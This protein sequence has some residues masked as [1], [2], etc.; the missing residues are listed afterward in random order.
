M[1]NI[2]D[3]PET[4]HKYSILLQFRLC[5]VGLIVYICFFISGAAG[6]IYE[7]VWARQLS[8]FLGITTY[9][10]TAVI[11]AYMAGLAAG[12]L[13]IGRLADRYGDSLRL[14]AW[15]EM[16]VGLYA[17]AT[18]WLFTWIQSAYAGL[19]GSLGISGPASHLLRFA[20]ALIGMLMP[21]FLMGGTLPLL[22]RGLTG[23]LPNLA[24]VTGR[25]YGINTLGAT[26]GTW[27][28]G[29]LL[30]PGLGVRRTIFLGVFM[31]LA[32]AAAIFA[33]RRRL[34]MAEGT[35]ELVEAQPS[36]KPSPAK[37]SQA[38]VLSVDCGRDFVD[39]LYHLRLCCL[40][41]MRLP[42]FGH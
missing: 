26:L 2:I 9:A 34:S 31:N 28:A 30:L 11:T 10:N 40:W 16:G 27:A 35:A 24:M 37:A 41:Y 33:L 42:G 3:P 38:D 5:R 12:S 6:L 25:L 1:T 8:L 4:N 17:A 14:Y 36:G 39:R 15:L 20:L 21:T 18:P 19:A 22:I 7:V 32:V 23:N 29:Y 13:I